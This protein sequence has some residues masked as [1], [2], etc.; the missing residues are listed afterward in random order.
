MLIKLGDFMTDK[1]KL[2]L[3][4]NNIELFGF[5]DY[6]LLEDSLIEC[7]A[8]QRIPD[9]TST[10]ITL[11]F[12]YKVRDKKPSNISRYSAVEDYHKIGA[13][14]LEKIVK[15]LKENFVQNS[16]EFFIDN[17]PIDEVKAAVLSGLG[18]KGKNNLLITKK[19]GSFVFIGEILT[20]LKIQTV[21][22]KITYCI[23]CDKCISN[24]PSG[25]LK[26]K[27]NKCL[28]AITQQKSELTEK[29]KNMMK[30]CNTVWGCDI[31]QDVCPLNEQAE[32]T[33]LKQ[34][35]TSYRNE[36]V[37]GENIKN[38]AFEWRGE[39]VIKRNYEIVK[40]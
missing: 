5:C 13:E 33:N 28:S 35:I 8:K 30:R 10:V 3:T 11:V 25:F 32:K 36:Y 23:N 22:N 15:E 18:V 37:D 12:P 4:K 1:I 7:R 40:E 31:C 39:K 2:I 24:C 38:R 9:N 14:I 34:F 17:S 27:N 20:D 26:D 19:Y 29:E 16:F 21:N 6:F